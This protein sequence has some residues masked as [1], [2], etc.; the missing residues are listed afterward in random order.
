MSGLGIALDISRKRKQSCD[1][2]D[3][4]KKLAVNGSFTYN[5]TLLDPTQNSTDIATLKSSFTALLASVTSLQNAV[6]SAVASIEQNRNKD[7]VR[8]ASNNNHTISAMEATVD[9]VTL[10]A[11]DR[12]LLKNQTTTS[13]NGIYVYGG[14]G[15]AATRSPDANTA[16]ELQYAYVYISSDS[17]SYA[18]YQYKETNAITNLGT[19]PVAFTLV[20][21]GVPIE[22]IP[23]ISV[24][25]DVN[26]TNALKIGSRS[27]VNTRG[28]SIGNA[29]GGGASASSTSTITNV[30]GIDSVCIGYE[31]GAAL[32]LSSTNAGEGDGSILIGRSAGLVYTGTTNS[33][34]NGMIAIGLSAGS[35]NVSGNRNFFIGHQ[36][37]RFIT[38]SD[39]FALG[40]KAL[41]THAGT[42]S[43][44]QMN[45]GCGSN[46]LRNLLNG[47]SNVA[48]G[49]FAM[50]GQD[51]TATNVNFG[52]A[53]LALF[54][55]CIG[56]AAGAMA[57]G[58]T[59]GTVFKQ[60][61]IV[62]AYGKPGGT[63]P[64]AMTQG[65]DNCLFGY[66][67]GKSITTGSRNIVIG[68]Q[69]DVA[70]ATGNDQLVIGGCITG[71]HASSSTA[72][73]G[74]SDSFVIAKSFAP[75]SGTATSSAITLSST[76]NQT[77]GAS[78][79]S[80]G[81]FVNPTLTAAADYRAI[82][83][84]NNS[85]WGVYQS[86][87]SAKNYF[88]GTIGA[89]NSSPNTS[90]AIDATGDINVSGNFRIAG[91]AISNVGLGTANTWTNTNT[92]NSTVSVPG[93]ISCNSQPSKKILPVL[94]VLAFMW[95]GSTISFPTFG[96]ASYNLTIARNGT[97]GDY[98]LTFTNQPP[99]SDYVVI[100]NA[101]DTSSGSCIVGCYT[102]ST[103]SFSIKIKASG[104]SLVD[105]DKVCHIMVLST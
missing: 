1:T 86:G 22:L 25:T 105:P 95:T 54:N 55:T 72:T 14:A 29:A 67:A 19:D 63:N 97:A 4:Y 93:S 91:V 42:N 62:G 98:T 35:A 96:N 37:G 85:Q 60:N 49:P 58:T 6:N 46:A 65:Q 40:H 88:N 30:G 50:V 12:F 84:G 31:A 3:V 66:I 39:Q 23:T 101:F 73:S 24:G 69:A 45:M 16:S 34:G 81:L 87:A 103:T 51:G 70:S 76:V 77:G 41:A 43:N 53:S 33:N 79:I 32:N 71:N 80:R 59:S 82:E 38:Q 17:P 2:L 18:G 68:S 15:A 83:I 10:V 104:G 26:N 21:K 47:G 9:G 89:K 74:S 61:T 90:Y 75:T 27:V 57:S 20:T 102:Y 8:V 11:G 64:C 99:N 28:L 78:G 52:V 48:I 44:E 13:E 36:A 92:F 56:V 5:G 94:G 7:I 100:G